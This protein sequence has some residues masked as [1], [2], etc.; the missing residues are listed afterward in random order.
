MHL[1]SLFEE[2]DPPDQDAVVDGRRVCDDD[3]RPGR[4]QCWAPLARI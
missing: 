1:Y 2:V 4:A 3:Y